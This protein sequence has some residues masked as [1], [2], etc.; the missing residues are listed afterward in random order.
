MIRPTLLALAIFVI[1]PMAQAADTPHPRSISVQGSGSVAGRP[2][3]AV[4]RAGIE[5]RAATP[6]LALAANT[7][8]MTTLLTTIKRYG[9]A[10]KD[11]ETTSFD[12]SPVY[13]QADSRG[14]PAIEGYQV[15]NQV[16]VRVRDIAKLG[17]LLSSLVESGANRL[18]GV[19]FEIAEPAALQDDARRAAIADARKRAELYAK[20]AGV[21]LRRVLSIAEAGTSSPAP[22]MMRAMKG[23]TGDVPV[24]AG[25]QTITAGVSVV[26]E[27]E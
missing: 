25:E 14:A 20:A 3:L 19:T 7:K 2:D 1:A 10:D 15:A 4:A 26:Y 17:G 23:G 24:A 6:D 21:K 5:S 11:I 22:M 8:V 27:I 9:I 12:V 16:S 18:Q 13:A